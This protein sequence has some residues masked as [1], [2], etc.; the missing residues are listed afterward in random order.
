MLFDFNF[1]LKMVFSFVGTL[2]YVAYFNAPKRTLPAAGFIGMAEYFLY[3]IFIHFSVPYQL[4]FFFATLAASLM[5]EGAAMVFKAPSTIFVCGALLILVP[6]A[7][8]YNS[9]YMLTK[10]DYS[11]AAVLGIQTLLSICSMS[12]AIALSTVIARKIRSVIKG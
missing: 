7:D 6:G 8:I 5:C 12:M 4:C 3:L 2:M 9:V 11:G 10:G 1:L